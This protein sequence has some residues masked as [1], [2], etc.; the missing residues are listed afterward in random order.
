MKKIYVFLSLLFISLSSFAS[1][2]VGT[3]LDENTKKP[4]EGVSIILNG[5]NYENDFITDE[6]GSFS[7]QGLKSGTYNLLI[8]FNSIKIKEYADIY[9]YSDDTKV[10]DIQC[11]LPKGIEL[12]VFTT[13]HY[14]DLIDPGSIGG[15]VKIN[16]NEIENSPLKNIADFIT[17]YAGGYQRDEGKMPQFHGTREGS[18]AVYVDGVRINQSPNLPSYTIKNIDVYTSALP[19]K[20]GDCVGGVVCIET[21]TYFDIY[22]ERLN[23]ENSK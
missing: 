22:Q 21:K 1:Q 9:I 20:Y 18:M 2:L 14:K 7:F 12:P 13:V 6:S 17:S 5:P 8:V 3:L 4:L 16:A 23:R 15:L 19:A 11:A 10:M